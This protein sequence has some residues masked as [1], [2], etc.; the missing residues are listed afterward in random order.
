MPYKKALRGVFSYYK[1]IIILSLV[2]I[3]SISFF[4]A[5]EL[6]RTSSDFPLRHFDIFNYFNSNHLSPTVIGDKSSRLV[7]KTYQL[8]DKYSN[9]PQ[10]QSDLLE[11]AGEIESL[12]LEDISISSIPPIPNKNIVLTSKNN[13]R[14]S[15]I[16]Q[17]QKPVEE[18]RPQPIAEPKA[19]L[20][21]DVI[22]GLAQN[23][24]PKNFA[25]FCHSAREH[26]AETTTDIVIFVN[27]PMPQKTFEISTKFHIRMI[28]YNLRDTEFSSTESYFQSYHPSTLRWRLIFNF[29]DDPANRNLYQRVVLAD[30]RDSY[31]QSN[32]FTAIFPAISE[33]KVNTIPSSLYVFSEDS[34]L[35]TCGWNSGWIR[36]CFGNDTL[37]TIGS[38]SII[39]SGVTM[40][41]TD[42]VY[43]YLSIMN[44]VISGRSDMLGKH[45]I[46]SKFPSCERNGVD[47]GLHNVI[48]HYDLLSNVKVSHQTS[49]GLVAHLQ[50]YKSIVAQDTVLNTNGHRVAI[51]H[52]Y[53]RNKIFNNLLFSKYVDWVDPLEMKEL[54]DKEVFC[55]TFEYKLNTDMFQGE[56]DLHSYLMI[57]S[58]SECCQFCKSF[59]QGN[60]EAFTYHKG[61]C[62]LKNCGKGGRSTKSIE[63]VGA[64]SGYLID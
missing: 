64:V 6:Y 29:F 28:E 24:N 36:D 1:Y 46:T 62:Y 49:G 50:A 54:W 48:I 7:F 39:C 44:S 45:G 59:N 58:A 31:F 22:I 12:R 26:L 41:T 25:V 20:R 5:I 8:A 51:V 19:K 56:C 37:N 40:G 9:I 47:Q 4:S 61:A 10:L 52:Q 21:K 15:I 30:V 53:D 38:Q 3:F 63:V 23:I 18:L 11:I 60:C 16:P 55:N 17:T 42:V 35:S 27:T 32:P 2:S 34:A 14:A 33:G 57:S 13:L 43:Q